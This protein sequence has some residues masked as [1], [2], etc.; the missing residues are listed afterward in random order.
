MFKVTA[1]RAIEK[2]NDNNILKSIAYFGEKY[3]THYVEQSANEKNAVTSL[4]QDNLLG[5]P[6]ST[7]TE[8]HLK[9]LKRSLLT[10]THEID[11]N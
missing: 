4:N 3:Q 2:S 6:A 1:Y 10:V 11:I 8:F 7:Q 9:I 5:K